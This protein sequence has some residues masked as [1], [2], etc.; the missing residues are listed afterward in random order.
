MEPRKKDRGAETRWKRARIAYGYL[1]DHIEQKPESSRFFL[2]L[3][4]LV[5]V[6][7]FKG[8][9]ATI[10]ETPESLKCKLPHYSNHI[11][12]IH[13]KFKGRDLSEMDDLEANH[14]SVLAKEFC[15]MANGNNAETKIN[16]FGPSYASALL[17]AYFPDL[18]PILD[19]RVLNALQVED[20]KVNA[21]GQVIDLVIHYPALIREVRKLATERKCSL[22]EIDRALFAELLGEKFK[23]EVEEYIES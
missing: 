15:E 12:F 22:E 3:V 20:V 10:A 13:A 18:L 7:N 23:K 5:L 9:S 8:G 1:R 6:S 16:G 11:N 14:L 17:N 21:Q 4:D 2:S 19:R